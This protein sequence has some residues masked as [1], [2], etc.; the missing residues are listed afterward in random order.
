M[1]NILIQKYYQ[2][3]FPQQWTNYG[4]ADHITTT[5]SHECRSPNKINKYL[6]A[7]SQHTALNR[8]SSQTSIPTIL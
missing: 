3:N 2:S 7:R 6:D 4:D 1:I 5:S 8:Q